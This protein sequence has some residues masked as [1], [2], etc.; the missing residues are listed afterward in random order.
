[1]FYDDAVNS[2]ADSRIT[3]FIFLVSHAI[4]LGHWVI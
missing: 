3:I 2:V 1:M 4:S